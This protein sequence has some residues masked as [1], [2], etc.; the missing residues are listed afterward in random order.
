MTERLYRG[1]EERVKP[2]YISQGKTLPGISFV[3]YNENNDGAVDLSSA[4]VSFT[5]RR[6]DPDTEI[7]TELTPTNT[8]TGDSDGNLF[9]VFDPADTNTVGI[10]YGQFDIQYADGSEE[11]IPEIYGVR[12]NVI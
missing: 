11:V 1:Q 8:P 4:T 10:Y 2:Q 5:W 9:Y 6:F 3:L 12:V 7:W